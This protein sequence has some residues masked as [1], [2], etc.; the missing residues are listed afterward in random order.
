MMGMM[1]E[2]EV[3]ALTRPRYLGALP[4]GA[5]VAVMPA[6]VDGPVDTP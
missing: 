6:A 1:G 3:G 5:V 2:I 4:Y